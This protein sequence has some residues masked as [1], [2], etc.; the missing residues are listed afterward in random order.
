MIS[1]H[2][3]I[4]DIPELRALL[5]VFREAKFCFGPD[6]VEVS[7]SPIVNSM[8]KRLVETLIETDC[9]KEGDKARKRWERWLT[10]DISRD[11][12]SAS[13]LRA[14]QSPSWSKLS[15]S[16]R[17]NYTVNLFCPFLISSELVDTFIETVDAKAP[18]THF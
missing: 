1:S 10:I 9:K 8:F 5:R 18:D 17:K 14:Q 16:E 2:F 6:D 13:V 12:W 3:S 4:K 7:E 11:E 15:T